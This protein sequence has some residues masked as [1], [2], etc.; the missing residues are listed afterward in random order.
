[1]AADY[2][3]NTPDTKKSLVDWV[4]RRL[5]FPVITINVDY[6][7]AYDRID[8]AVEL[9]MNEH[10]DG[11]EIT[12]LSVTLSAQ[13]VL[14]GFITMPDDMLSVIAIHGHAS[15]DEVINQSNPNNTTTNLNDVF[16]SHYLVN[17]PGITQGGSLLKATS[18]NGSFAT[19]NDPML[20][21]SAFIRYNY[22]ATFDDLFNLSH[23]DIPLRFNK[24]SHK[25]HIDS[26]DLIEGEAWVFIGR[27][28][29]PID[30]V[31]NDYWLKQYAT[32]LIKQT[33][34]NNMRK[35]SGISLPGGITLD[36]DKLYSEGHAEQLRLEEVL[37]S[38]FSTPP[39]FHIG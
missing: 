32:A 28:S 14:N 31:Y 38:K 24:W 9:Y 10:M 34:G 29:S 1:M 36:G 30:D 6:Q 39:V 12:Y 5:G 25:L 2:T 8:E 11:S 16:N 37:R 18:N 17:S 13:D 7:Q 23:S 22:L 33:W 21:T 15:V 3:N 20:L 35:F 26:A 27:R 4:F 19:N